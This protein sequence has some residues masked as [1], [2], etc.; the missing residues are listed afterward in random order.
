MHLLQE[1]SHSEQQPGE[2][3]SKM[4]MICARG[5]S[6][7]VPTRVIIHNSSS[8]GNLPFYPNFVGGN[9]RANV[10]SNRTLAGGSGRDGREGPNRRVP[11][12]TADSIS[13]AILNLQRQVDTILCRVNSVESK[14]NQSLILVC[15]LL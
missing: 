6:G 14:L 2:D 9:A 7:L 5:E 3:G 4:D 1:Q 13:Y 11:N 10:P 8:T 12:D 15:V